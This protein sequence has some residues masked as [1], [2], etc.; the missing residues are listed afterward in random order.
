MSQYYVRDNTTP[1]ADVEFLSGQTGTNPVGPD[2]SHNI[3]IFGE[4]TSEN[5][6]QGINTRGDA[7]GN[8]VFVQLTNRLTGAISTNDATPTAIVTFPLGGDAT[9][10]IVNG[11]ISAYESATPGGA[12]YFFNAAVRTDGATAAAIGV[13]FTSEFEDGA[14]INSDVE[15]GVSGNNLVITVTGVAA[16]AIDWLCQATY[17]RVA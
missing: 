8:T 3:N 13:E 14:L 7:A 16:T 17:S 9:T 1:S 15:V 12:G 4:E 10:Y 5:N 6:L 11:V 2:G